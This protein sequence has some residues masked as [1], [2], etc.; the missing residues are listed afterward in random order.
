MVGTLIT[1]GIAIGSMIYSGI[2]SAKARKAQEK[3]IN[4]QK[5]KNEA[6]YAKNYNQDYFQNA[7]VQSGLS[8]LRDQ[9]KQN[10]KTIR[11]AQAM[12]GGSD[13]AVL[14]A[15]TAGNKNYADAV[16]GIAGQATAYKR[17]IDAQYWQN[18]Q[19]IT[20]SLYNMYNQQAASA[21]QL[22]QNGMNAGVGA[23]QSSDWIGSLGKQNAAATTTTDAN[24]Y[25]GTGMSYDQW[26]QKNGYQ[27][28]QFGG[29][30]ATR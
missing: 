11:G 4:E 2:K 14:A 25:G 22:G 26:M 12:R 6:W 9:I 7:D 3:L 24:N 27:Y 20:N 28:N 21:N 5:A 23:I 30:E 15:Q 29:L 18:N 16:R 10:N 13:E 17:G 8:T 1:A 19:G